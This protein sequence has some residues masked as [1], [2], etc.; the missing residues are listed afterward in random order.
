MPLRR[1]NL[2]RAVIGLL[3]WL[4]LHNSHCA[5]RGQPPSLKSD[6]L[7]PSRARRLLGP[8]HY[9]FKTLNCFAKASRRLV[10]SWARPPFGA[11]KLATAL[12]E[13]PICARA[14]RGDDQ[15]F[16]RGV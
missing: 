2:G 13:M 4:T 7:F 14:G 15:R 9:F 3:F 6:R 8:F 5:I 1:Q 10:L 12:R 11:L 16:W